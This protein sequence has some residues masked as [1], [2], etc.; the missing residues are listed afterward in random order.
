MAFFIQI[1]KFFSYFTN[2]YIKTD[3]LLSIDK[4]QGSVFDRTIAIAYE[5]P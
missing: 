5:Y 1:S 4:R 2:T 3:R